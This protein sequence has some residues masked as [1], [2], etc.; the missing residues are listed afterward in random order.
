MVDYAGQLKLLGVFSR[1]KEKLSAQLF[2]CG[3]GWFNETLDGSACDWSLATGASVPLLTLTRVPTVRSAEELQT[4]VD[5]TPA[6]CERFPLDTFLALIGSLPKPLSI[7]AVW[8][9]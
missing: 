1:L 7:T 6:E 8:E 4:R 5:W 9:N 2:R 3:R